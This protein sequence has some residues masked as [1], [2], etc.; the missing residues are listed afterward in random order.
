MTM[1]NLKEQEEHDTDNRRK[2]DLCA[3]QGRIKG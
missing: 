2:D 1:F 3:D